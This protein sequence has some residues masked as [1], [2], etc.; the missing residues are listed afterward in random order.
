[1][2]QHR[3]SPNERVAVAISE[4][5]RDDHD[6]VDECP[7]PE[8]AQCQELG[9]GDAG[10]FRIE[11][12]DA[13]GAQKEAEEEGCQPV[14]S[15]HAV[16]DWVERTIRSRRIPGC[17]SAVGAEGRAR[18]NVSAAVRAI[19]SWWFGCRII[20]GY[21]F[22]IWRGGAQEYHGLRFFAGG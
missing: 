4:A 11:A 3:L 5:V 1:L 20:L 16:D 10:F 2:N 15:L 21:F 14:I 9:D 22:G 17:C 13:E 19:H 18:R 7:D 8:P 12:M 6:Q